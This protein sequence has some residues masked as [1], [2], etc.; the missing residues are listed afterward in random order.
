MNMK[1]SAVLT[2]A[3]TCALAAVVLVVSGETSPAPVVEGTN[4][5]AAFRDGLYQGRID[6]Q[7]GR[8]PH[9]SSGRW[10]SGADRGLFASGYRQGYGQGLP[11]H[12]SNRPELAEVVGH[13][14]GVVDGAG[15]RQTAQKFQSQRTE[16]YRRADHGLSLN[17]GKPEQ[18][19]QSYRQAYSNGYQEGF[20]LEESRADLQQVS[21]GSLRF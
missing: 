14:D 7:Q 21:Q 12:P 1:R 3:A 4:T 9:I 17:R 19:K 13:S 6:A 20:Y 15:D 2:I 5:G 11:I 18:Y 8:K 16:N 10:T